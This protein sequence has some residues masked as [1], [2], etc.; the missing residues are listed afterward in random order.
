M[1]QKEYRKLTED[2]F[3]LI[4]EGIHVIDA[5]EITLIYNDSMSHQEKLDRRD[6]LGKPFREVFSSIDE[7]QSTML[8]ALH[9]GKATINKPQ[10]YVNKDGKEVAT[11]NSTYP[12]MAEGKVIAAVEIT[13]NIT[14]IQL[15]SE[16]IMKLQP[17]PEALEGREEKKIRRYH[18][19]NLIGRNPE[20]RRVIG[21]AKKAAENDH[22]VLISGETGTG[23]ELVAQ[24]I[25][26]GSPRKNQPF[27]AQNCAALPETLLE[28]LLFGTARGGF[29]G[30][31]DRAG[32]FEQANGGTLLLDELSAMPYALQGKL[33]RV[34][35]EDYIRRVGGSADIP[36]DVRIIATINE[37][38]E[39]LIAAGKLRK[40]LYYRLNI[41]PIEMPPLRERRDDIL[42]L[43]ECFLNKHCRREGKGLEGFSEEA[44]QKLLEYDYPGN[45][46]ELENIIM[47]AVSL[48]DRE[49][50][51]GVEHLLL[52]HKEKAAF[53]DYEKV[54]EMG[55]DAYLSQVENRLL[56][57][58]MQDCQGN[59]SRAAARLGIKRQSLQ[60]KLRQLA[61]EEPQGQK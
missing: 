17:E 12:I 32:L 47:S 27:L 58:A 51:L 35:Q 41:L 14:D 55:L 21:L 30:A 11:I 28:G 33:L 46:R 16:T 45:I 23:K 20:F 15:M 18:F 4:E 53:G 54:L 57:S 36:V 43:A 42:L 26:F 52:P 3:R 10:R 13:K 29:T 19:E 9:R 31:L 25:H 8:A 44:R 38:A 59:I 24:S 1:K 40:D 37:P 49:R 34:L 56:L 48:S 50:I 39:E 5:N 61:E 60:Y 6:V 2:I 7:E 22:A